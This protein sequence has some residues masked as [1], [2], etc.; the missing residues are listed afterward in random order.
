MSRPLISPRLRPRDSISRNG[1]YRHLWPH[2]SVSRLRAWHV[3]LVGLGVLALVEILA[4]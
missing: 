2:P 4:G 1:H 3:L